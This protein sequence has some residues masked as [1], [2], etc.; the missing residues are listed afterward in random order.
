MEFQ[1]L[2]KYSPFNRFSKKKRFRVCSFLMEGQ[3]KVNYINLWFLI[4]GSY[5]SRLKGMGKFGVTPSY[6]GV[7][8][9]GNL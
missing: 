7:P 5:F 1:Y 8:K 6:F 4:L 3:L 9:L 2:G